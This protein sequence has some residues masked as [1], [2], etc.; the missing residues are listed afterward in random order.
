[1]NRRKFMKLSA[2]TAGS[3]LASRLFPGMTAPV[4]ASDYVSG[5]DKRNIS[6]SEV[7]FMDLEI[8]YATDV[9][10]PPKRGG[11]MRFWIPLPGTDQEQKI[12][13]LEIDSPLAF[14]INIEPKYGNRIV[15]AQ[16]EN[17]REGDRIAVTYHLR[18]KRSGTISDDDDFEKHLVLT[19]R[20]KSN[21]EIESFVDSV[22]GSEKEP[23][24]VGRKIYN[25]IVDLLT[26]DKTIPGCG[27]GISEWTYKN[28]GGRCDDFHALFRTMMIYKGV[29]VRWE[30]GIPLPYPSQMISSGII[31]GDCTGAHCWVRFYIGDKKW[32]PVDVSEADKREDMREYFFGTLSPNRFKVSTGRDI[33][34]SPAQGGDPLNNFPFAYGEARG[35]PLIYAHNFRNEIRYKVIK[36]EA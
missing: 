16:S 17:F 23:L 33:I 19:K 31:E 34:L 12:T 6:D 9:L 7:K 26:Y 30:Q 10:K 15:F 24:E 27:M 8:T 4:Y 25:A 14:Q 22:T 32:V 20:E 11:S 3:M 18:R 21:R 28:K 35:L 13:N 2:V 36:I 29:P 1:M 5:K